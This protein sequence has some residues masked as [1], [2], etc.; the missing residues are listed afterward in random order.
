[1][2]FYIGDSATFSDNALCPGGPFMVKDSSNYIDGEWTA[3]KEVWC[4]LQGQYTHM[5]ADLST[6]TYRDA[7]ICVLGI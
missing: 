1:M 7:T 6:A 3:G 4:N 2:E 5:I